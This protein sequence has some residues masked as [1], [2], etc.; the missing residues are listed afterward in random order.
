MVSST[1]LEKAGEEASLGGDF[2]HANWRYK[3]IPDLDTYESFK[4]IFEA[5]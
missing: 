4:Y 3:G 1:E 2:R 5:E